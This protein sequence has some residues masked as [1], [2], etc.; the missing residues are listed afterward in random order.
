MLLKHHSV[1]LS[2]ADLDI[3]VKCTKYGVQYV[4]V[5]WTQDGVD[6]ENANTIEVA[7]GSC[8]QGHSELHRG[9]LS[10]KTEQ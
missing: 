5:S 4:K 2:E 9:T 6:I 10:P 3:D 7:G 1:L 8:V